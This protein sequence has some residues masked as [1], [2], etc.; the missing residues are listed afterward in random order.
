MQ[1]THV[2]TPESST[3]S[4]TS[5]TSHVHSVMG[6]F[7]LNASIMDSANL[8]W[9]IGLCA[10]NL[11]QPSILLPTY[12]TE[13]RA[14]ANRIIRVSGS[15]LR[16]V[17]NSDFPLADL[18]TVSDP[19]ES[20]GA[21]TYTPGQDLDFLTQFFTTNGQFLLGVDAPYPPTPISSARKAEGRQNAIAPRNGV[22]AP[23]PRLCLS[24]SQTGYL[25]DALTGA[26][27]FHLVLFA[28]DLQGPVRAALASFSALL[29][30]PKAFYR[31]YGRARRF[32][33]VLVTTLL[34]ADAAVAL[35]GAELKDVRERCGG[36]VLSDDR[37]PDESAHTCYEVD[38]GRGAVVVVRPDLWIG[39]S[40][41]L[42]QGR[43]LD[44]YFDEWLLPA[45]DAR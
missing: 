7:G 41:G 21:V 10:L 44:G 6:A 23:N 19:S 11:A 26:A 36:R 18:T 20:P 22:R 28:S 8:A 17:C 29:A 33:L 25:Y 4:L 14:H 24:T 3:L 45:P 12:D 39:T 35:E 2:P 38:H 34:P 9:K 32:N 31:T 15:Y 1:R 30:D 16:F 5:H 37:A 40:V 42:D 13:R 27:T 43:L